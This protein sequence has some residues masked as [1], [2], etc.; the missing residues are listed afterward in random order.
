MVEEAYLRRR[1]QHR[2]SAEGQERPPLDWRGLALVSPG[3]GAIVFG[4]SEYGAHRTLATPTAWLPLALGVLAI[5]AFVVHGLHTRY[6]IID[7]GLFRSRGF[8]AA[9]ATV[10]LTGIALFGSMILLP[11]YYQ[12]ARGE[13]PLIAGLLVAPQGLGAVV[14]IHFGGRATDRYGGGRVVVVGLAFLL[15]GTAIF[16]QVGAHTSY[17]LIGG[18]LVLRGIGLGGSMMPAMAAAYATLKRNQVPRA[19]PALNVL[20]RLG[21]SIGAALLIVIL[22]N[23]IISS[24]GEGAQG[25]VSG[26]ALSNA[27]RTRVAD[28]L[29]EAFAHTYWYALALTALALIPAIVLAYE[30]RKSGGARPRSPPRRPRSLAALRLPRP[31]SPPRNR[32]SRR[33][34]T[35]RRRPFIES[36]GVSRARW[37]ED[38]RARAVV[39]ALPVLAALS[40]LSTDPAPAAA[41]ASVHNYRGVVPVLLYHGI[42][43]A[44]RPSGRYSITQAEFARQ[45]AMLARDGF[46]AISIAQYARFTT[47]DV[48]GLPDRPILITF[49]DGRLDSYQGADAIL[50]RYGMRATMF[51]IT[52]TAEAA[53]PGYLSW[54]QL[55]AMAAGGR[56]DLQEHAHVGHVRIPTGPGGQTGPYYANLIYRNGA[57]E[58]F[59]AFKRRVTADILAGRRL[60]TAQIPGF[61]PLAFAVPYSDYGQ[62]HT[63]YAPIPAWESG[64]LRRTFKAFFV[65]DRRVY[66]L[67]GKRIG[68]RYGIR[69]RTTVATLHGWLKQALPQS[70]WVITRPKRPKVRRL[71]VHRRSVVIVFKARD[72]I[73][74]KATRRRGG[75]KR[76]VRVNVSAAGRVRDKRLRPGTVY[77]YRVV[78]VDAAGRRSRALKLRVRTLRQRR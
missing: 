73:T 62:E 51:V 66:N 69:A 65:Q 71:R 40:I 50:G 34:S 1:P 44:P 55:R 74:L 59:S 18:A 78:A 12:I 10:F 23:R 4:I 38:V 46:H 30:E 53:K 32:W 11:L 7:V 56:W 68:Q 29:A 54:P 76:R 3:V 60:M 70:A 22:Q 36:P 77:I 61:E 25:G 67:P 64:W 57:R 75:R 15:V 63:N 37:L 24:L 49:D 16:T 41:D 33:Y 58:K 72:G 19:T 21:G 6:P 14:G 52:A 39:C 48:E 8:S 35:R 45:M 5:V 31:Q 17:W 43:D 13:S 20:Q 28:P 2:A 47:G 42:D 9:A 26:A 27:A